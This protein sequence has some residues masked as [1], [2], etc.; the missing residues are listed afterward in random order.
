MNINQPYKITQIILDAGVNENILPS[1]GEQF[2]LYTNYQEETTVNVKLPPGDFV[3][4]EKVIH[5]VDQYGNGLGD[6][7]NPPPTNTSI[8]IRSEGWMDDQR[9]GIVHRTFTA[10]RAGGYAFFKWAGDRWLITNYS[11]NVDQH[12]GNPYFSGVSSI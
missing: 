4:E 1:E 9:T 6:L 12:T 7:A 2:D 11:S 8:Y 10:I 5:W 3:G